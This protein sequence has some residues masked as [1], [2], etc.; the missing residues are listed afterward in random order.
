MV[1]LPTEVFLMGIGAFKTM[2]TF[3]A[4]AILDHIQII[5]LIIPQ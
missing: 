1:G 3:F 2:D 5:S 4:M